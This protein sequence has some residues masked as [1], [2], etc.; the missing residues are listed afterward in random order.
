[1]EAVNV[2]IKLTNAFK[3]PIPNVEVVVSYVRLAELKEHAKAYSLC[4]LRTDDSGIANIRLLRPRE[5]GYRIDVK[6]YNKTEFLDVKSSDYVEIKAFDFPKLVTHGVS[7][8]FKK[9]ALKPLT[10]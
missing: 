6:R 9:L 3:V 1:N 7:K 8:L 10:A 4:V 5:G 2:K